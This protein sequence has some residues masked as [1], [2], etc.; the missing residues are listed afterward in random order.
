MSIRAFLITIV[1]SFSSYVYVHAQNNTQIGSEQPL[2]ASLDTEKKVCPTAEAQNLFPVESF[3]N[4]CMEKMLNAVSIS[5]LL[6]DDTAKAE[7]V[8]GCTPTETQPEI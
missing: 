1:F 5:A 4:K 6:N 2:V 7:E 8:K 3:L